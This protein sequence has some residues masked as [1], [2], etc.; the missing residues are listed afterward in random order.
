MG[1]GDWLRSVFK[2]RPKVGGG[3]VGAEAGKPRSA[4]GASSFHLIWGM[5][6]NES[7]AEVSARL[8]VVTPPAVR[9]LY[10]WA[11]QVSFGD[12]SGAHVGLQQLGDGSHAANWGGY[13]P[14]GRELD[15][16]PAG[17]THPCPWQAGLAY[18]L[19]IVKSGRGWT[20]SITDVAGGAVVF[21]R[22]LFTTGQGLSDPMVWSEV[23]AACDDPS[24]SVRWEQ[25]RAVGVDGLPVV[26]FT[27]RVSYQSIDAGGCPNTDVV[28]EGAGFLQITSVARATAPD[29]V[30]QVVSQ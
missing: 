23:F 28:A 25:L 10:F 6:S 2:G 13:G 16:S 4:N 12:G 22:E 24:V 26:P 9:E 3:G 30:L 14:D 29:A 17:N 5:P 1:W 8:T 19:R 11:L 27:V 20:A 15:G 18:D 7:L 21:S